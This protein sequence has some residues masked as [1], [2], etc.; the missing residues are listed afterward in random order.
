M[1]SGSRNSKG[2]YSGYGAMQNQNMTRLAN[3]ERAGYNAEYE[4]SHYNYYES[5]FLQEESA[6]QEAQQLYEEFTKE[7]YEKEHEFY[8]RL[9]DE[10]VCQSDEI[11]RQVNL[12]NDYR[13]AIKRLIEE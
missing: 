10:I 5:E 12:I 7:Q 3:E 11:T 2:N 8:K 1:T 4:S 13:L 9:T 6:S